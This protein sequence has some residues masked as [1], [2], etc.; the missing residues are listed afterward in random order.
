MSKTKSMSRG[1]TREFGG[2]YVDLPSNFEGC[3]KDF[4]FNELPRK[5]D[6]FFWATQ[7]MIILETCY[8][9]PNHTLLLNEMYLVDVKFNLNIARDT[10]EINCVCV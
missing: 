9:K 6:C 1:Y 8:P 5:Y 2:L 10:N 7:A 4:I 3:S